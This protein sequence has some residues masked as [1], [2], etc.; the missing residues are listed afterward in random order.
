MNHNLRIT[1]N[2]SQPTMHNPYPIF[3]TAFPTILFVFCIGDLP[4]AWARA[5]FRALGVNGGA[6]CAR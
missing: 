2:K 1:V 4:C 5:G 6:S 3:P